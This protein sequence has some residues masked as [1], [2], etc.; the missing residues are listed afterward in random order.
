MRIPPGTGLTVD[1]EAFELPASSTTQTLT[2]RCLPGALPTIV[3]HAG[4]TGS[5]TED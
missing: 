1:G 5:E 2:I 3:G 4:D